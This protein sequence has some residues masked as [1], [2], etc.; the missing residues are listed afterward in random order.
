MPMAWAWRRLLPNLMRHGM[1]SAQLMSWK[2]GTDDAPVSQC[3]RGVPRVLQNHGQVG[4]QADAHTGIKGHLHRGHHIRSISRAPA[5]LT[6]HQ[7]YSFGWQSI[8]K[9]L[10]SHASS[11]R[12]M[13]GEQVGQ[14][15][16]KATETNATATSR[17]SGLQIL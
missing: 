11:V 3:Q 9:A 8:R 1:L 10:D 16:E 5:L 12:G 14:H 17:A 7:S 4:V 15:A 13:A 2:L 6:W